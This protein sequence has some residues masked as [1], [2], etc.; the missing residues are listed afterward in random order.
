[1][2]LRKLRV[3]FNEEELTQYLSVVDNLDIPWIGDKITIPIRIYGNIFRKIEQIKRILYVDDFKKLRFGNDM[4]YYYLA[5]PE[6]NI[7]N[8]MKNDIATGTLQFNL[9]SNISY[10]DTIKEF[11]STRITDTRHKIK[12]INQGSSPTPID[13]EVK[14]GKESGYLAFISKYGAIQ[15]GN[16]KE[17]D[18]TT[19]EKS[20]MLNDNL[21]KW[22]DVDRYY[23]S[24]ITKTGNMPSGSVLGNTTETAIKEFKLPNEAKNFSIWTDHY[25][26][27]ENYQAT[28]MW[29]LAVLGNSNY[30]IVEIAIK[31]TARWG[32]ATMEVKV[33]GVVQ[34]T[35][36]TY[37]DKYSN[38]G[39]AIQIQKE[40]DKFTIFYDNTPYVFTVN[41]MAERTVKRVQFMVSG[42]IKHT[43]SNFKMTQ[44]NVQYYRDSPNRFPNDTTFKVVGEE[45][46]MYVNDRLSVNDEVLGTEYFLAPPGET[47]I[48]IIVSDFSSIIEAKAKIRERRL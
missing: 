6:F 8:T 48:D 1:M 30:P 36:T 3:Y 9:K 22:T 38:V 21:S 11:L 16:T 14:I 40:R 5:K 35:T 18:G 31:K 12:V 26:K 2:V 29:A 43:L 24:G 13:Y 15:Y 46:R 44:L 27:S 32:N 23:A 4:E 33:G 47:E 28:G 19:A 45:G 10:S 39:K 25:V 42:A 17:T 34:R 41:G 7:D 20:V 37:I